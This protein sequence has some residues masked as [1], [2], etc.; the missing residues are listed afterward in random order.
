MGNG[1]ARLDGR[2]LN[3][4]RARLAQKGRA[5]SNRFFVRDVEVKD[6]PDEPFH[7][8]LGLLSKA[9]ELCAAPHQTLR[10]SILLLSLGLFSLYLRP[11][12]PR[13]QNK[14]PQART[15]VV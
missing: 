14:A 8:A 4:H 10:V 7:A 15:G 13:L 6:R 2:A 9:V 11:D 12:L 5:Y 3:L 1:I